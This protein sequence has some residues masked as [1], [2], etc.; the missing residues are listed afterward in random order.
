M[1]LPTLDLRDFRDPAR[2][3]VFVDA[4]RVAAR[5]VGF[6]HLTHHGVPRVLSDALFDA[7]REFFTLPLDE[8]CAIRMANSPHFRGYTQLGGE[9]TGGRVDLREQIDVGLEVD[10][11]PL[12]PGDPPWRRLPGPNQWPA[13]PAGFRPAMEAWHAALQPVAVELLRGFALSLGQPEDVFDACWRTG[14]PNQVVKAIRYPG[15]PQHETQGCGAH[16]DSEFLTLLLQDAVGGLE[17]VVDGDW[18]PVPPCAD[19]FVVNT[20]E[21]LELASNGYYCA[22][23]H[24]VRAPPP[25]RDRVSLA[26]FFAA[27]LDAV[28]P[29]LPLPAALARDAR[30]VTRDP[31]N[32]L[33]HDVG[34][35]T[36]KGRLRSHPDVAA[37][38]YP[39]L[40]HG[41]DEPG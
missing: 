20:G 34:G 37:R 39:D 6:F 7:S 4:L 35:N 9:R 16:K 13:R 41:R 15:Q 12:A 27:C 19:A 31:S 40:L 14:V 5:D 26:F 10:A 21:L 38:F 28:V 29:C 18:R 11:L 33:F 23:M 22:T 24:R 2:R 30:G 1:D 17:V 25:D 3:R 32:P 8:K 36:L